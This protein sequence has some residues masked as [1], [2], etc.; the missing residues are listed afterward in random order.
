M[1]EKNWELS[2]QQF[3]DLRLAL[4]RAFTT[5]QE[6]QRMVRE[7]LNERLREI[8]GGETLTDIV[9]SLIEWAEA[10]NH[11]KQLVIS[12]AYEKSEN[13][14]IRRFV[15][16]NIDKLIEF[17]IS[18]LSE[19]AVIDLISILEKI[20]FSTLWKT[21]RTV[22]PNTVTRD[23]AQE[24]QHLEQ[25]ELSNWFKCFILFKLLLEAFPLLEQ[26]PSIFIFVERLLGESHLDEEG[27]RILGEWLEK[28]APNF[29]HQSDEFV[30]SSLASS[31]PS[32]GR[33]QAYLMILINPE[34]TKLR[35]TASLLC[36]APTGMKKE[37]PVHLNPESSERGVLTTQKKLPQIVAQ[38]VQRSTSIELVRP[39]NLLGCAYY[40]LTIELFLPIG[41]LCEPIDR[42]EIK[43]D[44]DNPVSLGSKY[45]LVVRSYDRVI[46]PGLRNAFAEAWYQ[47]RDWLGKSSESALLNSKVCHLTKIDS[48]RLGALREV[49]KEKIGIKI[50]GPLPES[51]SEMLKFLQV[52]LESGVPMGTWTRRCEHLASNIEDEMD[53]VWT[54]ELIL[55]PGEFLEKVRSIRAS[56]FDDQE[57]LEKQW[58][59][60]LTVLWDDLERMPTLEPLQK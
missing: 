21:G 33:L 1:D 35:A 24:T 40:A 29:N 19:S 54:P 27:N 4:A 32:S 38:F 39:E 16:A 49:L 34:K 12:A 2:G 25:S 57:A 8:V 50:T 46:R 45:R 26:R 60:H 7:N 23:R 53:L 41:Y 18:L 42:W 36:S 44:F 30:Q 10:G 28:F 51:E 58:G 6:L 52:M 5:E 37:I 48:V 9:S 22:L 20:D 3:K 59:G 11:I 56:A 55:N 13:T 43:D 31:P 47:T 17:D 14:F 15:E